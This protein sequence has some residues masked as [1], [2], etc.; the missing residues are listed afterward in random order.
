MCLFDQSVSCA[1]EGP[2]LR[3]MIVMGHFSNKSFAERP[4][5]PATARL[6]GFAIGIVRVADF[7]HFAS[8]PSAAVQAAF[9][10]ST[11]LPSPEPL[12]AKR[13]VHPAPMNT[14]QLRCSMF[15]RSWLAFTSQSLPAL[16][17]TTL[18]AHQ[19]TN[20]RTFQHQTLIMVH[21][22]IVLFVTRSLVPQCRT[23][24]P[25]LRRSP[26][27]SPCPDRSGGTLALPRV[28]SASAHV[29]HH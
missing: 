16:G 8:P 18:A 13:L 1:H 11:A 28:S 2:H 24:Q 22:R 6:T 20:R 5:G 23:C 12:S 17:A 26:C 15:R 19:E 27:A 4:Y 21:R 7:A 25:V 10:H 14:F 29:S 9:F 3:H